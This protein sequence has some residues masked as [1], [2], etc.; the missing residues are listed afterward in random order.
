[1]I[2]W[3]FAMADDVLPAIVIDSGSGTTKAG[4]AGDDPPRTVIPT[5]V[6][7]PKEQVMHAKLNTAYK[8]DV[9]LHIYPQYINCIYFC[10]TMHSPPFW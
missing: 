6:G 5:I 9:Q 1:M 10:V 2:E 8:W 4:F 7:R 3:Y